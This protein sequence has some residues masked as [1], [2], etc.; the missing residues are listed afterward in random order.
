MNI[1]Q[2]LLVLGARWRA[3]LLVCMTVVVLVAAASLAMTKKYTATSSLVLDVKSPDPIAG[4]VLPGMTVSSYMGTQVDVLQSE[5]VLLKAIRKLGMSQDPQLRAEWQATTGGRGDLESWIAEAMAKKVRVQPSK[6]SNVVQVSYA[7]NDPEL[8]A[9]V[10]NAVVNGYIE[11]TLELRTEPAKQFS[12]LFDET[13]KGLR[14]A[15]ESA[16]ARLSAFQEKNG[17]VATDEKLDIEN[18]QLA[19]LSTQMTGLEATLNES[20][21]RQDQARL[22]GDQMQEVVSNQTIV[23]LAGDLA[24]Q[25]ARLQ[26]LGTRYG[27]QHPQ[28][29]ELR[30]NISELKLRLNAE[31]SRIAGGL[32]VNNS[33]NQARLDD[34]RRA[35]EK[36]RTRVGQIKMQRDEALVLQRDVENAQRAYDA[37]FARRSQSALESQATQTNVSVIKVATP[38]PFPSSPHIGLNLLVGAFVGALLGVLTAVVRERQ[39]WRLRLDDD[40]LDAL[41]CPL[42]GVMPDASAASSGGALS[43]WQR[44]THGV[45][46]LSP[47]PQAMGGR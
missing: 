28:V 17:I 34:L 39:D 22:K 41:R 19:E 46:G 7:D 15:L 27:D 31:R 30:A 25:E 24:S 43:A 20:R 14:E 40:V 36:Q 13:T 21:S 45:L 42:I 6:D 32:A 16:Q 33:I 4:V 5:R 47:T 12:Q 2:V 37:G 1:S 11:T 26:E 38:P 44:A 23:K 10:A 35:F 29:Q 3:A 9:A 8:A 18:A